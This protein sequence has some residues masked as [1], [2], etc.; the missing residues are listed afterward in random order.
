[1]FDIYFIYTAFSDD[2]EC[3][4]YDAFMIGMPTMWNVGNKDIMIIYY[5]DSCLISKGRNLKREIKSMD[6]W[7][8]P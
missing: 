3:Y 4:R 5:D 2:D 8:T 6:R 7:I 1:M